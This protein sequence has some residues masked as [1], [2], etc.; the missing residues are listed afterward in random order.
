MNSWTRRDFTKTM[1][2]AGTSTA[3]GSVRA[4]EANSRVRL[5]CIGLGNRGDQVLD[6]FLKHPDAEIAAVCDLSPAYR[7]AAS[8]KTGTAPRQFKD[9]RELLD[10]KDIDAVVIATPDHWH[11]LQTV[12]ACQAGKD[13]YV[14]K[15]LSL[16]VAEGRK[17]V[18]AVRKHDRVSQVGIHRRS[19]ELC[20]QAA[21][22]VR[23]GTLGKVTAARAFHIQNEW[24]N[25]IGNPPDSDPPPGFDWDAWLGPAPKRSYNKNR[26]FYRFRWF[27]DYSGGQVTNFGVHY[28]DFIQWA[29]GANAPLTVTAL[30]GKPAAMRDNR[31]IPDT[32]EAVWQ[33]PGGTLVTFSQFNG[34]AGTWSLPG[35]ELELRGTLGTLYLF[36][37]GYEIVPD[38]IS[39]DEFPARSPLTR[40]EDAQYRKNARSR[41]Q[42]AK[43][44]GTSTADTAPHAR[45][46]LDCVKSRARCNCDIEIGHRSTSATLLANIAYK[47]RSVLDW[48][49]QA[50][51]FPHHAEANKLLSYP[52]RA[53][54]KLS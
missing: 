38:A 9:Y 10:Q 35:C 19:V 11:A 30:G 8:K 21:E 22:L 51:K 33:Y 12:H 53:P 25:G 43:Q 17:M 26:T 52:Y 31:E 32:L 50:E 42:A 46:F 36:G 29:L 2:L 49:A 15:P 1:V 41:I 20:R 40:S 13:V 18:E 6:A 5:G 27:Y 4:A 34:N 44:R 54:Y 48:D 45:N 24:P 3:L 47:T 37:D 14:E 16:C 7:D 23:Q 39:E 28:I